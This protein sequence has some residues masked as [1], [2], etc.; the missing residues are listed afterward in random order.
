MKP[1]SSEIDLI[2]YSYSQENFR[3]LLELDDSIYLEEPKG[4]FGIPDLLVINGKQPDEIISIEFKLRNW[5]R[6][7]RQAFKYKAFSHYSYVVLDHYY[8]GPAIK[9]VK[10]F[11][12]SNIGLISIQRDCF[13]VHFY[14]MIEEPYQESLY[15]KASRLMN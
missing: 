8:A 13:L 11:K 4:L 15:L 3:S 7:L 2:K 12:R 14:P 1:Y 6:A 5:K 10:S 9:N